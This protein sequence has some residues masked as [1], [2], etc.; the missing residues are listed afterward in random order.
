MKALALILLAIFATVATASA[1]TLYKWTDKNGVVHYSDHPHKAGAKPVALPGLS[2]FADR[3]VPKAEPD[4]HEQNAP[5]GHPYK[6]FTVTSPKPKETLHANDGKVAVSV[7]LAPRLRRGDKL[8]YAIDGQQAGITE[9][10]SITL[11]HVVRGTRHLSVSVINSNGKTVGKAPTV[12]F[13]VRHHSK[14]N[15]KGAMAFPGSG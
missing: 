10:T 13:Y 7:A 15:K 3:T 11:T 9:S 12:T 8:V 6:E 5:P 2:S 14:L 4:Q 1:A